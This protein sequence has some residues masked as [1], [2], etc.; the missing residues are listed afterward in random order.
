M[1]E[2]PIGSKVRRR[3]L[4]L[5]MT[6]AKL[7]KKIGVRQSDIARWEVGHRDI[8]PEMIPKL[9]DA[10]GLHSFDLLNESTQA[11]ANNFLA[12]NE[13]LADAMSRKDLKQ[14]KKHVFNMGMIGKTLMQLGVV[15]P[16]SEM[17]ALREAES[18]EHDTYEDPFNPKETNK[19]LALTKRE[20]VSEEE[21]EIVVVN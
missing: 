6:Q 18:M 11:L 21:E 3:R 8:P 5:G 20:D 10:L 16:D 9:C 14:I 12:A 17:K 1:G 4:I 2:I 7:G 15:F 13:L 19:A